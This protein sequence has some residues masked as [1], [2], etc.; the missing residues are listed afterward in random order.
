MVPQAFDDLMRKVRAVE[1]GPDW[2]QEV[3]RLH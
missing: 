2:I 3:T 1:I